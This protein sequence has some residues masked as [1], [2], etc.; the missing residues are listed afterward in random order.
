VLG[1]H[2][3]EQVD[4][5]A[6]LLEGRPGVGV[7]ALVVL[8]QLAAQ[9]REGPLELQ[10]PGGVPLGERVERRGEAVQVTA[11]GAVDHPVHGH[12]RGHA[13]RP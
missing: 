5:G 3:L 10:R 11:D 12:R 1:L 13:S 8:G 7:L 2:R 6:E 4:I 9:V